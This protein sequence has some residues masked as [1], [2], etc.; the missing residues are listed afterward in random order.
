MNPIIPRSIVVGCL[1]VVASSCASSGLALKQ[2]AVTTL[3]ASEVV[4]KDARLA[5]LAVFKANRITLT[6]HVAFLDAL[7]TAQQAEISAAHALQLWTPGAPAPADAAGYLAA[8]Q[9]VVA[10][11]Q[12]ANLPATEPALLKAQALV[13]DAQA[14]LK[15]LGGS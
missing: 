10:A 13:V 12:A 11:L 3:T 4:M 1:L 15:A 8:A 5:E 14:I 6:Q 7:A 9:A 2:Q